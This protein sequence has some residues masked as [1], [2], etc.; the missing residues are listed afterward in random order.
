MPKPGIF[1]LRLVP[2]KSRSAPILNQ[3]VLEKPGEPD[4]EK[5]DLQFVAGEAYAWR[6]GNQP[7]FM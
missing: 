1:C 6:V 4:N 3:R 5:S 2:E 7:D